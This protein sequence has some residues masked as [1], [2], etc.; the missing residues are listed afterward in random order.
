LT[1]LE[2]DAGPPVQLL[3]SIP[4]EAITLPRGEYGYSV[5]SYVG[6][7]ILIGTT[8]GLRV[9]TIDGSGN[10]SSGPL[11]FASYQDDIYDNGVRSIYC[12]GQYAYC[13]GGRAT[14]ENA[15]GGASDTNCLIKV[16]LSRELSDAY[17]NGSGAYAWVNCFEPPAGAGSATRTAQSICAIGVTGRIAFAVKGDGSYPEGLYFEKV[18]QIKDAGYLVT[19]KL[20]METWEPKIFHY[21]KVL[22]S[23]V[24]GQLKVYW[25][26][27]R[28]DSFAE[29]NDWDT[30]TI[31][32]WEGEASDMK[33]VDWIQFK[34]RLIRGIRTRILLC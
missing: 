22:N 15:A 8:L 3:A 29:L 24:D 16:D 34:F 27:D 26:S 21:L 28:T 20:R 33:F 4:E 1:S 10:I 19:G 14:H 32:S 2:E 5:E 9:G 17:G 12:F 7:Y 31:R 6:S 30:D 11:T 23:V 13:S 25:R 18:S